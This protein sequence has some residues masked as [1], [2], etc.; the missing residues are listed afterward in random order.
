MILMDNNEKK[1]ILSP[2]F[3]CF[4]DKKTGLTVT[5]GKTKDDNPD[6]CKY[7]P[8]IADIEITDICSGISGQVCPFCYKSNLPTNKKNMSLDTFKIIFD[9]LTKNKI[10]TQIAFGVDSH[11]TSNPDV[12]D[13]MKYTRD[14]GVIPN[15]TVAQIDEATADKLAEYCGAV[16]VSV[17]DNKDVAYD[18]I[19]MLTDRG[20]KQINIHRLVEK[21]SFVK[22]IEV[23]DDIKS[24][25][26]LAKLNAI[27]FLSLKQKGRGVWFERV[28]DIQFLGL[29]K[30]AIENKIN[31][32]FDSCT[33]SKFTKTAKLLGIYDKIKDM[34]EPCESTLFSSYINVDG[35]F[36]PCS[37]TEKT[38]GWET[39]IDVVHCDDF[40]KDVWN[41]ERTVK[42]RNQLLTDLDCNNCRHCPLY[43]I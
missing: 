10:L 31:F 1:V 35:E 39:G 14:N 15:V 24:D 13:I 43:D 17:Y 11:C 40:I 19:K 27:V 23:I 41:N 37:F 2:E 16:A 33:A 42:F 5:Y 8:L 28:D 26:R 34:I 25:P 3:N 32:G 7:G 4:F 36:Y 29:I 20:M 9:K 22:T 6:Y 38:A 12:W 18:S 30:H 21:K